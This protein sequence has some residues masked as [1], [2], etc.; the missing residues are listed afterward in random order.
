MTPTVN[1]MLSMEMYANSK[2]EH[3]CE[4]IDTRLM[5]IISREMNV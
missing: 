5:A 3:Y 4:F 2:L 1:Q